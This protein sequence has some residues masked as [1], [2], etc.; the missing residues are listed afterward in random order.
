MAHHLNVFLHHKKI[1]VL[2]QTD[3]GI[4]SFQ[5]DEEHI[6]S[7]GLAISLCMPISEKPF[8]HEITKAF[9][10]GILPDETPRKTLAAFLG[11]SNKNS[12]ALLEAIGGECAGALSLRPPDY[13]WSNT[14]KEP[15][16]LDAKRLKEVLELIKRR[17]MLAGEDG[18]RLSLAGAQNK[19]AVGYIDGKIAILKGNTPTTHILKPMIDGIKDSVQNELFCMRLAKTMGI[20][21]PHTSIINVTDVPCY[22]VER[23]DRTI[24]GG[25]TTRIHQE[26]F[27]QAHGVPPELK[28]EREGGPSIEKCLTTLRQNSLQPAADIIQFIKI[29]TFNFLIG[30]ADAHG[31][32]YSLLYKDRKPQLAPAYDIL[33]TEIYPDLSKKMA[34]KIGGEYKPN[35]ICLRHWHQIVPETKGAKRN[36]EKS[37]RADANK[38]LPRAEE[39]A[40]SLT[41]AGVNSAAFDDIIGVI[42]K[43]ASQIILELP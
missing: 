23:Y 34:M 8:N 38:I 7:N 27:C 1:G 37:L 15:E 25:L 41:R 21:V 18:V 22:L 20:N 2:T 33:S 42:E 3:G 40:K 35:L 10:S 13:S 24:I 19:L 17:P 26:D 11:I 12:F 43:R 4:L 28:Y 32:N 16:I 29:L 5:Y 36:L 9:F 39:L 6:A 14:D 30:N 31:K